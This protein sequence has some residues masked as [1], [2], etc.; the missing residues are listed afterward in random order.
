MIFNEGFTKK[1]RSLRNQKSS[2]FYLEDFYYKALQIN[3]DK[4]YNLYLKNSLL[5][6]ENRVV[7]VNF[8]EFLDV[9]TNLNLIKNIQIKLLIDMLKKTLMKDYLNLMLLLPIC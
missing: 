6:P 4:G 9:S 1:Y 3:I 8:P 5:T 2:I 7:T